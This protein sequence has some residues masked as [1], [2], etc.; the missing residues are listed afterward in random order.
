MFLL[1]IL[2]NFA[3]TISLIGMMAKNPRYMLQDYPQEIIATVQPKS[4]EEKK[5]AYYY[6]M[7]FLIIL[8]L[9]P[10]VVGYMR[11]YNIDVSFLQNW[12][13]IFL[14][15]FSF[16]IVDLFI[17]DWLVFCTITPNFIIIPGSEGNPAYKDYRF[18]FIAF[19]KGSA[20][21]FLGSLLYALFIELIFYFIQLLI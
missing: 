8:F 2:Y 3:L 1:I 5:G 7:P 17:I 6:G 9:Y 21:S 11:K 16:N 15:M 13:Q 12:I 19:L 18:H 14:L 20:F 4:N 10:L